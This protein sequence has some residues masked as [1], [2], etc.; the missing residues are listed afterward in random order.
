MPDLFLPRTLIVLQVIFGGPLRGKAEFRS[1]DIEELTVDDLG[2]GN[3]GKVLDKLVELGWVDR[4]ERR[5]TV[6]RG[7]RPSKYIYSRTRHG[8]GEYTKLKAKLAQYGI[9]LS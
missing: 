3:Y 8:R 2:L 9:T 1:G 4:K 5:E 6:T 7:G